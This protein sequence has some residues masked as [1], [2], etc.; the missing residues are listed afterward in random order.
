MP[1]FKREDYNKE[2]EKGLESAVEYLNEKPPC[3]M[4]WVVQGFATEFTEFAIGKTVKSLKAA[5][6]KSTIRTMQKFL[7]G[8]IIEANMK[9]TG[10]SRN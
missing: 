10:T 2:S 1:K 3:K 5:Y 4:V 8:K 7:L 9:A 6:D